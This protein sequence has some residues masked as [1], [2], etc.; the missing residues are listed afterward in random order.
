MYVTLI[1]FTVILSIYNTN[2]YDYGL[3]KIIDKSNALLVNFG[4][5]L[6]NIYI[7]GEKNL[8][9]EVILNTVNNEEYKTIFDVNLTKIHNSLLLNDWIKTVQIE[10]ILPN[11]IKIQIIE[12]QPL[13]IWQTKLV[14]F[15]FI[16][17]SVI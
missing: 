9:K 15:C 2:Q 4:F 16:V 12:K 1:L 14:L 5:R 8:Q 17:I 7:T 13:A 3:K 6:Q 11:S 10:R